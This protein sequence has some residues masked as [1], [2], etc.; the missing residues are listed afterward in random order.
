MSHPLVSA[1]TRAG[2]FVLAAAISLAGC[3]SDGSTCVAAAK[4][5][6]AGAAVTLTYQGAAGTTYYV[7]VDATTSSTTANRE[8]T[9]S[10]Q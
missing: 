3:G 8:F 9:V 1:R 7:Y 6:S 2:A 5:A 10:V 4:A